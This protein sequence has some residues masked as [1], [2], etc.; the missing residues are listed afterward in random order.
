MATLVDRSRMTRRIPMPFCGIV[1][2][3]HDH[4]KY[5]RQTIGMKARLLL[6]K[7]YA[8][9]DVKTRQ[10]RRHQRDFVRTMIGWWGEEY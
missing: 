7:L 2:V 9:R 4:P 6:A 1:V 8:C 5:T 10:D 3:A